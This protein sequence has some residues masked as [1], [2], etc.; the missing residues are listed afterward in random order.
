MRPLRALALASITAGA[1][2]LLYTGYRIWDPGA[3][4]HQRTLAGTLRGQ[5]SRHPAGCSPPAAREHPVKGK[6][7]A[8]IQV[9]QFGPGWKFAIVEGASLAQLSGGPGHVTGTQFPGEPGNFAVAAHD[10]T[11]GN[12]FLHL[13]ALRPG[14]AILVTTRCDVYR[15]RVQAKH[16]VRYTDVAVLDAVPGH[17][18]VRPHQQLITLITCTP[19]TL[20]FT[21]YRI[22][23][24]GQLVSATS[25][26]RAARQHAPLRHAAGGPAAGPASGTL[27]W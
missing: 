15:Y 6:P 9:P 5:W 11:A 13:G 8:F 14:A 16:V 2:L 21:P 3:A 7:F 23:V 17:P 4:Q 1:A 26:A 19:V 25:K 27:G 22:I 18:G 12:P 24:T 20:A 10:V